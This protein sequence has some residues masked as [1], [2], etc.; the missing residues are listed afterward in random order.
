MGENKLSK[1]TG[2]SE[3]LTSQ[4]FIY[5]KNALSEFSI[6]A[7]TDISMLISQAGHESGGF[8]QVVESLSYSP[9]A[10]LKTYGKRITPQQAQFLGCTDSHP[11]HQDAIANIVY[12]SRMGNKNS[13]D[14]WKY[15]G[16]GLIQITGA[17]NYR[18]CGEALKLDLIQSPELLEEY[19][20]AA[21]S[22]AWFYTAKGCL[23][24]SDDII[25]VTRMING[26]ENGLE[27]RCARFEK[28]F[29]GMS[30]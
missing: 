25:R 17:E 5:I 1:M 20:H 6:T 23:R 3:Q 18:L 26:G 22:A 12:A 28:A 30:V 27:D 9:A 29:E 16:R 7:I 8:R 24:H 2:I 11:V 21:R 13:D 19:N 4:W 10:L 14:G 15:R